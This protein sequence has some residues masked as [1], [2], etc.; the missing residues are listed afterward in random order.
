M[1]WLRGGRVRSEVWMASQ[2]GV[3]RACWGLG[4]GAS[5]G[6][7]GGPILGAEHPISGPPTPQGFTFQGFR[8]ASYP[9][10]IPGGATGASY[11]MRIYVSGAL[12]AS[13]RSRTYSSCPG[14]PFEAAYRA[15][16]MHTR[17]A[18]GPPIPMGNPEH[19]IRAAYPMGCMPRATQGL[20]SCTRTAHILAGR[21]VVRLVAGGIRSTWGPVR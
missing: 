11:H 17:P 20:P 4:E 12:G 19:P 14:H 21:A 6:E 13:F 15:Q 18:Q 8:G 10:A 16:G 7:G 2:G 9:E 5:E 1:W 3:E